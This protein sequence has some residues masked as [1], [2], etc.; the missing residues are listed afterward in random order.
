V[1]SFKIIRTKRNHRKIEKCKN[2]VY[3]TD[4]KTSLLLGSMDGMLPKLVPTPH[5]WSGG[6]QKFCWLGKKFLVKE[7]KNLTKNLINKCVFTKKP[8]FANFCRSS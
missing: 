5:E 8:T 7:I 3:K 1:Q 4:N 6:I 2:I